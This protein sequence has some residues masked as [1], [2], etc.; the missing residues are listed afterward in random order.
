MGCDGISLRKFSWIKFI[1]CLFAHVYISQDARSSCFL[2]FYQFLG[3]SHQNYMSVFNSS[4]SNIYYVLSI[5]CESVTVP[6]PLHDN[7]KNMDFI[8][9]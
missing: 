4:D 7:I 1:Q 3:F 6:N 2:H 8:W 9:K 5:S